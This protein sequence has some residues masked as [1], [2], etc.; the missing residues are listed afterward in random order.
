MKYNYDLWNGVWRTKAEPKW[1]PKSPR[2]HRAKN[3]TAMVMVTAT[4]HSALAFMI[5][6]QRTIG[7]DDNYV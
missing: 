2:R 6:Y 5:G 3:T 1:K 4:A 7:N